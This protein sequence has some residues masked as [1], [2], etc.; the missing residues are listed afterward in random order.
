M[1]E[2]LLLSSIEDLV[3]NKRL[4]KIDKEKENISRPLGKKYKEK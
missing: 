4:E 1:L 2:N 3:K